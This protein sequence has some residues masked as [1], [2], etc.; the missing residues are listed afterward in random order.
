MWN[1]DGLTVCFWLRHS[2]LSLA[3]MQGDSAVCE[4]YS[5]PHKQTNPHFSACCITKARN[6]KMWRALEFE[7]PTHTHVGLSISTYIKL[8]VLI[9]KCMCECKESGGPPQWVFSRANA[10]IHNENVMFQ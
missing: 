10:E 9:F 1:A 4:R 7:Q 2:K 5:M 8:C 3:G 6:R